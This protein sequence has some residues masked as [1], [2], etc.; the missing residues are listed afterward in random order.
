MKIRDVENNKVEYVKIEKEKDCDHHYVMI[1]KE[2]LTASVLL[3][4]GYE[5]VEIEREEMKAFNEFMDEARFVIS[6]SW[7]FFMGK[8][9]AFSEMNE[10]EDDE[11][12]D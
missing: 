12:D 10:E 7:E 5:F 8:M 6:E 9:E 4:A 2:K 1:G 11:G 3:I